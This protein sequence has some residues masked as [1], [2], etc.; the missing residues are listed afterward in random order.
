MLAAANFKFSVN[1]GMLYGYFSA[2]G[3]QALE[4]R[5]GDATPPLL[6]HSTP[7]PAWQHTLHQN[8][9][10]YFSGAVVSFSDIPLDFRVGTPFQKRVWRNTASIPYGESISYGE[11]ARRLNKPGA[12]QAVGTALGKN[13]VCIV[14][15]CHRVLAAENGLGGF[16][17]GLHW[18]RRLLTLEGIS[19]RE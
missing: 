5:D 18:K 1:E 14:V 9:E 16:S 8:L 17:A 4:L 12:A 13:P 3:L 2:A 10:L 7:N 6:L 19:F 11:L 15:P